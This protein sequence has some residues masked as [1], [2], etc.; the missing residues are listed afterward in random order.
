[1]FHP[2]GHEAAA[3]A[4]PQRAGAP[5]LPSLHVW[6]QQQHLL[7]GTERESVVSVA[8][9]CELYYPVAVAC[10]GAVKQLIFH[11]RSW[12]STVDAEA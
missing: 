10:C 7:R 2:N 3:D 9:R 11:S 12:E 8:G 5:L 6:Q 4:T 1:M